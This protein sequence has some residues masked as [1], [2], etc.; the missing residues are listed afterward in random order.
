MN[1]KFIEQ[2]D[3]T[4]LFELSCNVSGVANCDVDSIGN[5]LR[6]LADDIGLNIQMIQYE[7]S[8][9]TMRKKR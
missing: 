8:H 6:R 3:G 7:V 2:A 9:Y 1:V 5:T 4:W